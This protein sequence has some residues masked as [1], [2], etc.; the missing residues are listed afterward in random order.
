[1]PPENYPRKSWL[2]FFGRTEFGLLLANIAVYSAVLFLDP[3]RNFK[4][5]LSLQLLTTEAALLGIF[6]I[7]SAVVIIAG[8]IDLSVGSVIA[9]SGV[10]CASLMRLL[11]Q[12]AI[13]N[14]QPVGLPSTVTS[15]LRQACSTLSRCPTRTNG[16]VRCT[17]LRRA[18]G[19]FARRRSIWR[20]TFVRSK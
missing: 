8:G 2:R 5:P 12:D 13:Q 10:V 15:L 17:A 18:V 20:P 14:Y 1:M 7:G 9:F 11:A 3:Q 6:A 19:N 4:N 16:A